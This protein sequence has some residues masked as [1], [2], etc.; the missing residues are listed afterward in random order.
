MP[1]PVL[2][3]LSTG[4]RERQSAEENNGVGVGDLRE[5][6]GGGCAA[7]HARAAGVDRGEGAAERAEG[8][9]VEVRGD[10][11]LRRPCSPEDEV[12]EIPS[13]AYEH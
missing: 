10:M 13:Q 2:E 8:G 12:H 1:V 4:D 11:H 9:G 7:P 5:E 6:G 3:I